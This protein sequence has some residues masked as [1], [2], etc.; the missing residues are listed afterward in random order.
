MK[1]YFA[2][3]NATVRWFCRVESVHRVLGGLRK[4]SNPTRK[5][6]KKSL[7]R[8]FCEILP[9]FGILVNILV[10]LS[11]PCRRQCSVL[12]CYGWLAGVCVFLV[13]NI[14]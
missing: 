2:L 5:P 9:G 7:M 4:V 14:L 8:I 1:L 12:L 6:K 3:C 10:V 13:V 11:C